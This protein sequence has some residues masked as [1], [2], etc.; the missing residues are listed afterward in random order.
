MRFEI[1]FKTFTKITI[2]MKQYGIWYTEKEYDI[3][4]NGRKIMTSNRTVQTISGLKPDTEY[5]VWVENEDGISERKMIR[6]D[7]EY[8]MLDV[9]KFGAKGDGEHDDTTFIQAAIM[10]CPPKGR[11]YLP[12][13]I[14]RVTNLF[15]KSNIT[16]EIDEKAILLG[17]PNR[18]KIPILPGMI[19]STDRKSEYNLGTWEG[20]PEDMFASLITGIG[21]A[22]VV[23]T[24]GGILDGSGSFDYWWDEE[25]R[26]KKDG[27]FRPR[28]IF[29]NHCSRITVQGLTIQNSPAWNLH[30]Y[31]SDDTEWID[32]K[33][34]NPKDSPN[35]DGMDPESVNG[36]K[37]IGIYFSLGDDCI[38]VKS[39][40]YYMGNK[41]KTPSQNI[42]VRQCYMR[43]GHGG[44][45]LGSEMGAG[46]RNLL[47][48]DCLFEGTDRG[49][50][51][52]TRRGRGKDAVLDHIWFDHIKMKGV[53]TPFVINSFYN[54][55]DADRNSEYV[56]SK[57][58][59]PVDE[60]TPVVG[61]MTF[62]N[63]DARNCHV[64]ASFLYGLPE[65]KIKEVKFEHIRIEFAEHATADYPAMMDDLEICR[66]QGI[67]VNNVERLILND[68]TVIGQDGLEIETYNVDLIERDVHTTT[69]TE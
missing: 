30:P 38:A 51:I 37:A 22:D 20:E 39:G 52:K 9:K 40:K 32:L 67:Y 11:I 31:F 34:I 14:Y 28:M 16:I 46:V 6:T 69:N 2:E 23:I 44:L 54:R 5:M 50:R 17:I 66:K 1:I 62:T 57:E 56:R 43:D 4:L 48:R 8:V 12:E 61:T 19:E 29:L 59:L 10:A 41:Y 35:T 55:C 15:L 65:A 27:A 21:I 53:L 7:Y 58:K 18:L 26:I 33:V 45:T 25:R 64:A 13:G 63:I 68:V 3:Y 47:C 42:E 36:L 24:G 49:L 60:G